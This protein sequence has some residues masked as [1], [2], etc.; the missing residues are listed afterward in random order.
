MSLILCVL[1]I[2]FEELAKHSPSVG[3]TFG[4]IFCE[5]PQTLILSKS[6]GLVLLVFKYQYYVMG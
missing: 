2:C 6:Y 5:F 3:F 1:R 4:E